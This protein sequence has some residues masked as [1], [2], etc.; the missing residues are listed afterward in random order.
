VEPANPECDQIGA[1]RRPD[2]VD[3][4][5]RTRPGRTVRANV[6]GNDV[7]P[8]GDA[9]TVRPDRGRT[10]EG[11]LEVAADGAFS[12]TPPRGFVGR[13]GVG[14]TVTDG[15][16]GSDVGMAWLRA[17]PRTRWRPRSR[18]PR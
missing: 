13:D 2:A 17:A 8:D 3:D 1:N 15:R 14:Y 11:T 4:E 9:L 7:D 10:S 6:L 12:Y 5:L 18:S 16:G